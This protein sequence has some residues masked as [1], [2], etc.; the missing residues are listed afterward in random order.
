MYKVITNDPYTRMSGMVESRFWRI[1]PAEY[2][3]DDADIRV[4][5][6][7]IDRVGPVY[8]RLEDAIAHVARVSAGLFCFP[9]SDAHVTILGLTQTLTEFRKGAGKAEYEAAQQ[10]R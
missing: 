1:V 10:P 2:Q 9:D 8:E 6:G 3:T 7:E 4:I 5:L